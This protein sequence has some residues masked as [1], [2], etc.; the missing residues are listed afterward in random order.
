ME[1]TKAEISPTSDDEKRRLTD[2]RSYEQ[3]MW[4]AGY[5]AVAGV[6]EAGRGPLAGPVVAAACIVSKEIWISGVDDSKKLAPNIRSTLFEILTNTS[7]VFFGV[8][9]VSSQEIDRINI[10]EATKAAMCQAINCLTKTP[11]FLLIDGLNLPNHT[12][13]NR[14]I[15]KGDALSFAI[16]AASII[17]K[18]TR[19]RLMR[20]C[21]LLFPD[22]GFDRHK[23]Y[24]TEKHRAAI[25]K[26][27]ACPIHR[28]TFEPLKSLFH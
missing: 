8:G 20:E 12:I 6:D 17:A 18:E 13:P 24:G 3:E 26:H 11:D 7:G 16:A 25:E 22:Y 5:Q 21:H 10:L 1:K 28:M 9:I 19:D 15:V 2:L 23:G 27:G 4:D 14:K